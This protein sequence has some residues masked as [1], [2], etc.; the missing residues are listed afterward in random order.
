MKFYSRLFILFFLALISPKFL[1]AQ[2]KKLDSLLNC[3]KSDREDTTKVVHLNKIFV[4]YKKTGDYEE[5]LGYAEKAGK[6]ARS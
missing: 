4:E 1:S 3:L 6:L 5:A 2:S